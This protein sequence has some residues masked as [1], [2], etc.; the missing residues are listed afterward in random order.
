[1]PNL[2]DLPESTYQDLEPGKYQFKIVDIKYDADFGR[3]ETKLETESGRL[4]YYTYYLKDNDGNPNDY[5]LQG[6]ARMAKTALNDKNAKQIDP[7]VLAGKSFKAE[8]LYKESP[9][10]GKKYKNLRSYEPVVAEQPKPAV[11][12]DDLAAFLG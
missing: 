9:N 4:V 3:V 2:I 10:T 5:Q 8:L 7:N 11:S 1:M 12:D 6:F